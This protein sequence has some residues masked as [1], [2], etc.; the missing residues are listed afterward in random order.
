M[1][2]NPS[3]RRTSRN[4][5]VKVAKDCR[6]SR[7]RL[8]RVASFV[9]FTLLMRDRSYHR[10]KLSR[11]RFPLLAPSP[12]FRPLVLSVFAPESQRRRGAPGTPVAP[13][14]GRKL[15]FLASAISI[16]SVSVEKAS[17]SPGGEASARYIHDGVLILSVQLPTN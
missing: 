14:E 6:T 9:S 3:L 8:A 11:Y 13:C 5:T 15:D 16:A 17:S 7:Y 1:R 12:S 10:G 4:V 2:R